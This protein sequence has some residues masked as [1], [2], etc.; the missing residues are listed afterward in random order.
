MVEGQLGFGALLRRYRVRAG[1]TQAALASEAGLSLRGISDLERGLRRV[2]YPTTVK[3]LVAT[4]GLGVAEQ[5]ALWA[6][7]RTPSDYAE[8]DT[9]PL[10]NLPAGLNSFVGRELELARL[11]DR[12]GTARLLNLAGGARFT[13]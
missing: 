12:L 3:R 13:L 11:V 8:E 2:P 10:H 4:L 1:L 6:A 5:A 7:K 9:P